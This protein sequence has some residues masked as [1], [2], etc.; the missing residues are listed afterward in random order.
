MKKW[1][2]LVAMLSL[3]TLNA[4]ADHGSGSSS[5]SGS[6]SVSE[7]RLRARLAGNAIGNLIPSG[8]ADFRQR[9]NRFTRFSTEV[10]DVNLIVDTELEVFVSAS[11]VC[12]GTLVGTIILGPPPVRGGDLNL[13]TRDGENV[14]QMHINDIV[15]VC[16]NGSPVVSG[17]LKR[18][19]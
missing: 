11:S 9:Q 16:F 5:S 13:D 14:P 15:S 3:G 1:I 6:G 12:S 4:F 2:L 18:R 19:D 10:E 17:K 7:I 8:Q